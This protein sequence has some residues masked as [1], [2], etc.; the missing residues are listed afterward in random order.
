MGVVG[1]VTHNILYKPKVHY[2]KCNVKLFIV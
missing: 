2:Y 1:D